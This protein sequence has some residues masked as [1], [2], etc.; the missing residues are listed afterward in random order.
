M[1]FKFKFKKYLPIILLLFILII[2][3]IFINNIYFNYKFFETFVEEKQIDY[4]YIVPIL[5][6]NYTENDYQTRVNSDKPIAILGTGDRMPD[7]NTKP[8]I[9]IN[10]E[11]TLYN[12]SPR[13]HV[14]DNYKTAVEDKNCIACFITRDEKLYNNDK[15]FYLPLFVFRGNYNFTSSPFKREY[16]NNERNLLAAY[17][18]SHSPAHRDEFF[19]LLRS[20][21]NTV[22]GLGVANNTKYVNLPNTKDWVELSKIYKD[23][24]FGFAMENTNEDGYI[25]EKIMNV[26]VGGAIPIY[27]GTSKIKKIFNPDSFIYVNDYPSFEEC[28]NDIIAIGKNKKRYESMVN[29]PIFL[30]NLPID[31]SKYYDIPPPQFVVNIAEK[32]KSKLNRYET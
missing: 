32:I 13:K 29:A 15:I 11:A 10:D 17:I 6:I 25:T 7:G 1:K 26:Y 27:W 20:K 30:E 9:F 18:A 19:K 8:Y 2:C 12:G 21:D 28:T 24:K 31:Y 22:D 5:R 3:V 14:D 4:G 16:I 23:Y